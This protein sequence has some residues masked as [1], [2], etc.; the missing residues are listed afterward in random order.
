MLVV[1]D[2]PEVG[3]QVEAAVELSEGQ[4]RGGPAAVALYGDPGSD[5]PFAAGD[6]AVWSSTDAAV[7]E[8]TPADF[9]EER[10]TVELRD[11]EAFA[12]T[13][14]TG[15]T[16]LAWQEDDD[17]AIRLESHGLG[18]DQLVAMAE[19]LA[20]GE[21]SD[22]GEVQVRAGPSSSGLDEV[23]TLD[24][25]LIAELTYWVPEATASASVE[26]GPATGDGLG[27]SLVVQT[28][29]FGDE[30]GADTFTTLL[31]QDHPDASTITVGD[32]E[33][34]LDDGSGSSDDETS[35]SDDRVDAYWHETPTTVVL[36]AGSTPV[37]DTQRA[38]EALR[39]ATEDERA[40]LVSRREEDNDQSEPEGTPVAEGTTANGR[41]WQV[42]MALG[43]IC[44]SVDMGADGW[45][46]SCA[47]EYVDDETPIGPGS[48]ATDLIGEPEGDLVFGVAPE[49]T[50]AVEVLLGDGPSVEAD[51]HDGGPAGPIYT[52]ETPIGTEIDG[53]DEVVFYD[54]E[55]MELG[56]EER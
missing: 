7:L 48:V 31:H 41:T 56:R 22:D 10:P 17:L 16:V 54:T 2:A 18:E 52:A 46:T 3:F 4:P 11:T 53:G 13:S 15:A 28:V 6:L 5:T 36:V 37:E 50:V 44:G 27:P 29:T 42:R 39:P 34:W 14:R 8:A 40:D 12:M 38:I 23:A 30:A 32:R 51:L 9:D 25:L 20:V 43:T 35:G 26:Y 21:A 49:G 33:V 55:G 19:A 47:P 45:R 24:G 1:E